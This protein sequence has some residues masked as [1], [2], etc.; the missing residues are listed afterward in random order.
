MSEKATQIIKR[1]IQ[2]L[3]P[4]ERKNVEEVLGQFE[5]IKIRRKVIDQKISEIIS[6]LKDDK[7]SIFYAKIVEIIS[8]PAGILRGKLIS[9]GDRVQ[10]RLNYCIIA[11]RAL[12][13]GGLTFV[14]LFSISFYLIVVGLLCWLFSYFV[15][16]RVQAY[17]NI[18]LA[19]RLFVYDGLCTS[20]EKAIILEIE[21]SG[22]EDDASEK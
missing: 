13:F 19:A 8:N 6:L 5:I 22:V 9:G 1:Y 12:M 21:E 2:R 7:D 3:N 10:A 18:E 15:I 20:N 16:N 17:I 11:N 14:L 4:S